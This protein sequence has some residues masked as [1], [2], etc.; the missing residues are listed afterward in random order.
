MEQRKRGCDKLTGEYP[1]NPHF[2]SAHWFGFP[3]SNLYIFCQKCPKVTS[4]WLWEGAK[5]GKP[6]RCRVQIFPLM[7]FFLQKW[8]PA[9][10]T[11]Y[12][13]TLGF[14]TCYNVTRLLK[15]DGGRAGA[16][17]ATP[18]KRCFLHL[19]SLHSWYSCFCFCC[20]FVT[21]LFPVAMQR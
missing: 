6:Q 2:P 4:K 7:I 1:L 19:D 5:A 15:G 10:T 8:P 20:F 9:S 14:Q 17:T 18:G 21:R 13:V 11:W 12:S 16:S 3:G